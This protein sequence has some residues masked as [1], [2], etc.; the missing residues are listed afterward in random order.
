MAQRQILVGIDVSKAKIDVA[1]RSAQV[2]STFTNDAAGQ[3]EFLA[4]LSGHGVGRAV[5]EAS[6]G[7]EKSWARLLLEAGL[8]V[9]IVDPGRVRHFAKSAGRRAKNDPI[10]AWMIAW[11]GEAFA[12]LHGYSPDADREELDQ[13][14]TARLA[15]IGVQTEVAAWGEHERPKLVQK[16]HRA[17][18]KTVAAQVAL[19]EKA[20]SHKLRTVSSFAEY[21]EIIES[22]PGLAEGTAAGLLAFLPEL[23]R[24]DRQAAAA[25]V[26]IAPFDNDSGERHGQR[27][28]QGGRHKLR[29]LL[30][31]PV[32]G[33]AT[34][35]NPVLKAYYQ[36]LIARGKHHKVAMVAC[37]RKLIGILNTMLARG[38]KWDATK[39]AVA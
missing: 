21:A 19:L 6:G 31:M 35:H 5:L 28:I 2:R 30:Y 15:L 12:D 18:L 22:V 11:F 8:D 16:A 3:Q 26:G 29:C 39:H 20:I 9:V 32:L 33:A 4:W 23:G 34:R 25:L 13:L 17:M 37:M 1:I 7:Y 14:V 38:E 24:V 27:H 10:D 36:R